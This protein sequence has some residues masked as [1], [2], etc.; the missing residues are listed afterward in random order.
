M[1]GLSGEH[2]IAVS[3]SEDLVLP[4]ALRLG[5]IGDPGRDVE[6]FVKAGGTA[7][8]KPRLMNGSL[9]RESSY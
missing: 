6:Q 5:D 8:L 3:M 2:N 1:V 4:A 9:Q 7:V